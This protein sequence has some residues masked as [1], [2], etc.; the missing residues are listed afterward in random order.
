[1][2]FKILDELAND[3]S[4]FVRC[5]IPPLIACYADRFEDSGT[6]SE[7][8]MV[9]VALVDDNFAIVRHSMT[10]QLFFFFF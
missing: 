9:L 10:S 2:I 3:D 6:L 7:L 5:Q 4:D 8:L 1:M